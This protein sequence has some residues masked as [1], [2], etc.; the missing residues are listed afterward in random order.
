MSTK[1]CAAGDAMPKL[2]EEQD[3]T[4]EEGSEEIKEASKDE[5]EERK[6]RNGTRDEKDI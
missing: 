2:K 1:K 3:E 4:V 6:I 5:K